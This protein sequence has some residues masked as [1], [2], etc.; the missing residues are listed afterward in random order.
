MKT[1]LTLLIALTIF[2]CNNGNVTTE[3]GETV[4]VIAQTVTF[5]NVEYVI[6]RD[7]KTETVITVI[8]TSIKVKDLNNYPN[9]TSKSKAIKIPV[10]YE[11][12]T[13]TKRVD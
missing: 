1:F 7:A 9:Q 3:D 10:Y 5:N 11:Y 8:S 12:D 4:G 13:Y 2:S 6:F